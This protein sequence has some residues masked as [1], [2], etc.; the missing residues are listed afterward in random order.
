MK[1]TDVLKR[2]QSVINHTQNVPKIQ[3]GLTRVGFTEADTTQGEVLLQRVQML[4]IVQQKEYGDRYQATDELAQ[5]RRQAR[6]LYM[7]HLETARLA[8]K[9]QRSVWKTL[10]MS[11]AR[12]TDLFG[13]LAQARTFYNN[14][15]LV[16]P[17]LAKHNLPEA[18]LQQGGSMIGAVVDAYNVR[19]EEDSEAQTATRECRTALAELNAWMRRFTMSAR[20]AFADTPLALKELGLA[21]KAR[22]KRAKSAASETKKATAI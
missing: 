6:E 20:L 16:A 18:E 8:L 2:V 11:G 9:N 4:D 10:A 14:A 22:K 12:K 13:W 7:H 19:H 1:R 5:A 15:H 3:E 17:I 21:R